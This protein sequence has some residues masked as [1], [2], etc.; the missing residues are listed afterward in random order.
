MS[1]P[2]AKAALSLYCSR[3]CVVMKS[4]SNYY[5]RR[6]PFQ[7]TELEK[8]GFP[9]Y[10]GL[11]IN[12]RRSVS[13][14]HPPWTGCLLFPGLPPLYLITL[15]SIFLYQTPL[16]AVFRLD[17]SLIEGAYRGSRPTSPP[18][19]E[20]ITVTGNPQPHRAGTPVEWIASCPAVDG[21][22]KRLTQK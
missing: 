9:V 15:R 16:R 2:A 3:A 19:N 20:H 17:L 8:V 10:L 13:K 4:R 14:R 18:P 1:L 21:A 11:F 5:Q 6:R 7:G 22:G 12:L